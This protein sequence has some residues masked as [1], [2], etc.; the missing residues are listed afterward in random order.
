MASSTILLR[1]GI[2]LIH[3]AN[4]HVVPTKADILIQGNMISKIAPN[5]Q[6]VNAKEYDCTDKIICPGFIDTHHHLWQTLLKGRFGDQLLLDYMCSGILLFLLSFV[7]FELG[8]EPNRICFS[9]R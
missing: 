1:G 5:I 2:V 4:D 8:S 7:C 3:D 9:I 6:P